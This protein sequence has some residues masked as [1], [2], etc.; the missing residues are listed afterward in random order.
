MRYCAHEFVRPFGFTNG[1]YPLG[2][3]MKTKLLAAAIASCFV[4]P[5]LAQSSVSVYGIADAGIMYAKNGGNDASVKLVSG[6]A[7]GSR[8]GF[9]GTE[10]MGGGYKAIFTLEARVELDRGAQEAGNLSSNQGFALSRGMEALGPKLLPVV[11]GMM[12]P[13]ININPVKALFDRTAMVGLI[14]PVGAILAGR[15]YTPAYEVFAAADTFEAGTGGGWGGI[16]GGTGGLLTAGIAIR[17]DKS[18]QYRIELPS[19]IAAAFM[20]GTKNSGYIGLDKS[21]WSANVKYK[22]NGFDIGLGLG[23]GTDQAGNTGLI[24]NTLGGSYST[25]DMKFFGGYHSQKNEH[26]VLIPVFVGAWD[27]SIAPTLAPLGAATAGALRNVFTT[28]LARNFVL[29]AVGYQVG[30]HYTIGSGRVMASVSRQDDKTVWNSDAT[31]YAIG[32]DYNLSKRTDLYTV[33]AYIKNQNAGQYAVGAASATGGFTA[34]AGA[35]SQALQVG[36]RHR[37]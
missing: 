10:D 20:Y 8:L 11:R 18:V 6:I 1:K 13:A 7:D 27:A 32:Y 29:D 15:M 34:V 36:M 3:A 9:K 21:M 2:D 35:S 23:R 33:L 37:F 30:M 22:A 19:G 26:S 24:T 16:V 4:L 25:G 5:A 12:Q 31:Q 17:S 14:T 28:N